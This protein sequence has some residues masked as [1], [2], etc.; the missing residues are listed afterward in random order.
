M[1][2]TAEL[3][4]WMRSRQHGTSTAECEG[5]EKKEKGKEMDGT[6][7][8]EKISGRTRDRERERRKENAF[9][10]GR[11]RERK[12]SSG[13]TRDR[14]RE[15]KRNAFDAG[16]TRERK[17]QFQNEGTRSNQGPSDLQSD[18]SQS[19]ANHL[20]IGDDHSVVYQYLYY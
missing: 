8:P 11:T 3:D 2:G 19:E 17:I 7:E 1:P 6:R 5:S 14:E 15:K 12:K 20:M 10:A 18:V 13:R 16:R 9:D 4:Q